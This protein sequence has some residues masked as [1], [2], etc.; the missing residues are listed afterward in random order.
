M[1]T[2]LRAEIKDQKDGEVLF[3]KKS[4][5]TLFL[6]STLCSLIFP[7]WAST[8]ITQLPGIVDSG[9]G[10]HPVSA[11]SATV[12]F[13]TPTPGA[14]PTSTAVSITP[15]AL[16]SGSIPAL[17]Q[18]LNRLPE[19]QLSEKSGPAVPVLESLRAEDGP[20]Y[21]KLKSLLGRADVRKAL[22]PGAKCLL[23]GLISP[24]WDAF[25]LAGN[26]WLGALQG[27]NPDFRAKARQKLVNY[28]Q[29]AHIPVLI[30]ILKTPG[31]NVLAYE[32]LQEV[33]GENLDPNPKVWM[34]W[35]NKTHG[36][37][38]VVGH[39][40]NQN[41]IQLTQMQIKPFDRA[42]FWYLPEG[43]S[44]S[45][46]PY[47]KRSVAE[48]NAIGQWKDWA[49]M[50][51][52]HYVDQWELAKPL[53]DRLVHQSDPR[54]TD[55]LKSLVGDSGVG[56]YASVILAWR[57]EESALPLLQ[58]TAA[59]TPTVGHVLARGS[60]GDKT[61]LQ[62]LLKIIETHKAPLSFGIM[63]DALYAYVEK[64]PGV[65]VLPAEQAFELL[66]HQHF[67]LITSATAGEKRKALK[68]ARRW[69]SEN[70]EKLTLDPKHGYYIESSKGEGR[71]AKGE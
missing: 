24:R 59:L 66:A 57:K 45:D 49:N 1:K 17:V 68:K 22:N 14:L 27:A 40:F 36:Q 15:A 58:S 41:R 11:S 46:V 71:G 34:S 33:T 29:P 70:I 9:A 12:S 55:Y 54:I 30:N 60:L 26:L 21:A 65:G 4:L 35:W 43:V 6:L 53:F 3:M 52:K 2:D 20:D 50:E 13:S 16:P 10:K 32:V 63:D 19:D 56:E 5:S 18:A 48:Q 64:L 61:A 62:D 31:P 23:A 8:P 44:R 38:D 69:L 39:V 28:I 7:C 51:V 47:A 37:V 25:S 67:G 42:M